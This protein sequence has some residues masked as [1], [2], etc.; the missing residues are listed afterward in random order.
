MQ[1]DMP[2]ILG[3]T[4]TEASLFFQADMRNFYLTE[5]QMRK[6][7]RTVFQIDDAKITAIMHAYRV[8]SAKMTPSDILIAVASDVQFRLP[9]T[10][11]AIVKSSA[12][13]QA[14]VYLYD[15]G[16]RIPVLGGVLESP[17]SVDIPFAFGT[18]DQAGAM[19]GHGDSAWE[20]SLHLMSAFVS[21]ARTG[22]PNNARLPDWQPFNNETRT[23]MRFDASPKSIPNFRDSVQHEIADIKIDPFNRAALYRYSD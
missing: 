6:R 18:I 19:I 9:L 3:H 15:F 14:P 8:D 17:H 21:F 10:N 7:M 22:N 12:H 4:E 11:A 20:T 2:L 23:T 5:E 13:G 16:W 1:S